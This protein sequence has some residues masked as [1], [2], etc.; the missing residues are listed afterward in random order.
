MCGV[1]NSAGDQADLGTADYEQPG[2]TAPPIINGGLVCWSQIDGHIR[3]YFW[4]SPGD[5]WQSVLYCGLG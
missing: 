3:I 2:W 4:S 5:Y 1:V